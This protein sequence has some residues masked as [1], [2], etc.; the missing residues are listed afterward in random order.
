MDSDKNID[1]KLENLK[2]I[3]TNLL[4]ENNIPK[5][6]EDIHKNCL[7]DY[8]NMKLKN[9]DLTIV[10]KNLHLL[11]NIFEKLD[12]AEYSGK[13]LNPFFVRF[14]TMLQGKNLSE[15]FK[16]F[17]KNKE[18]KLD[19]DVSLKSLK[20]NLDSI[21]NYLDKDEKEKLKND[22]KSIKSK[23]C[24]K[25][26]E[27]K[28]ECKDKC[29]KSLN[30]FDI[31][32]TI[33]KI[34]ENLKDK[35]NNEKLKE[36]LTKEIYEIQELTTELDELKKSGK[37]KNEIKKYKREIEKYKREIT[38]IQKLIKELGELK[39][40]GKDKSEIEKYENDFDE[41]KNEI[42]KYESEIKKYES[43]I[44][45]YESEIKKYE[46]EIKKYESE[47]EKYIPEIYNSEIEIKSQIDT[48][49]KNLETKKGLKQNYLGELSKDFYK[50]C[51]NT[52]SQNCTDNIK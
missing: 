29:D 12:S 4:G 5:C 11:N 16:T 3:K 8:N 33:I 6:L 31:L 50:N 20:Q 19:I 15:S 34:Y 41:Y 10:E 21:I 30:R 49:I 39:E 1:A 44:K 47:I 25:Y 38:K 45:K 27:N 2:Y 28:I 9:Y 37:D 26:C 18:I 7:N 36:T 42:E 40:S 48:I 24:E 22:I 35:L 46:S 52:N 51:I 32:I 23:K 13:T 14:I 17:T 43:E